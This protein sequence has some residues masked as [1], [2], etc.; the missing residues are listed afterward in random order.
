MPLFITEFTFLA[1]D[2]RANL[3]PVPQEPPVAEQVVLSG[4]ASTR[5]AALNTATF[6]VRLHADENVHVALG[7]G[8]INATTTNRRLAAG[9]TEYVSIPPNTGI[10][11]IAVIDAA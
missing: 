4:P 9:Q 3:L 1:S 10:T 8:S 2:S 6:L 7:G 11:H 5:S